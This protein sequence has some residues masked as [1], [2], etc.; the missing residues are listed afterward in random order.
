L[1]DVPYDKAQL[2]LEI[3]NKQPQVLHA[4]QHGGESSRTTLAPPE[5]LAYPEDV[6]VDQKWSSFSGSGSA[7]VPLSAD[8]PAKPL[9]PGYTTKDDAG[10]DGDDTIH[11]PISFYRVPNCIQ[12]LVSTNSSEIPE[13]MDLVYIDFIERYIA[14]AAQFAGLDVDVAKESNVYMPGMSMTNLILDWVKTHWKCEQ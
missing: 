2:M 7:Q 9:V 11:A 14:L 5:Q 13:K 12:A 4:S 3:L 10:T 6:I 1:K 8:E